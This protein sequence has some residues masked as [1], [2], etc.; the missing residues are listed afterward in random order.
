MTQPTRCPVPHGTRKTS[1]GDDDA[2]PA[3]ELVG[4][5]WHVRGHDQVRE[6]LRTGALQAGFASETVQK[7]RPNARKPVLFADGEEHRTQRRKIA[8]FFAPATV[9]KRYRE[10]MQTRADAMVAQ[11]A[12]QGRA[13]LAAVT[14][15][16]AVEVAAQVVGLTNSDTDAMAKRLSAFF[17]GTPPMAVDTGDQSR[18]ARLITMLRG[19]RLM[20]PMMRFNRRDVAPAIAARRANPQADVISHL[21]ESGYTDE[22][23]LMECL[24]YGAAGMVTTREF[25]SMATWHLLGDEALRTQYLSADEPGRFRIL[26]EILRLEPVVG[27]LYR[28]TTEALDLSDG[29]HLPAGALVDLYLRAANADESAVGSQPLTLCPQRELGPGVRGEALSFGDGAHR[30]PGNAIAIQE[31]DIFL[32]RLLALPLRLTSTPRL[33]WD[34][35]IS[36][37]AVRD[38]RLEVVPTNG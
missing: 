19:T 37:Y 38:I 16:Y 6:V 21:I 28:R 35:L 3:V 10:L 11:I 2:T 31:S 25:I 27:H 15:R 5:T 24:T 14:M 36:G 18:F 26:H 9:D 32:T 17:E 20:A 23:I 30:C 8:R 34:E 29:T 7:N 13:D 4:T 22:E 33:E 12:A 1:R